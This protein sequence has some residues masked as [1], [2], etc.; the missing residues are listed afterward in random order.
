M[1]SHV[2]KNRVAQ[3]ERRLQPLE[4]PTFVGGHEDHGSLGSAR[5]SAMLLIFC[6]A[7]WLNILTVDGSPII[8]VFC[9]L[10]LHSFV[11]II[12]GVYSRTMAIFTS[13]PK[14]SQVL[15]E[16]DG[17]LR[18]LGILIAGA[19]GTGKPCMR[20]YPSCE[21]IPKVFFL[22]KNELDMS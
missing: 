21:L 22:G 17:G 10:Y 20:M 18:P 15:L 6:F 2:R 11:L 19:D 16:T 1:W 5:N 14:S 12:R 8:D 13:W 4:Q 3:G 9:S 7:H